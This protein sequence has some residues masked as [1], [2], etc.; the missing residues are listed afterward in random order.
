[1][2]FEVVILET[3]ETILHEVT[4][5]I[6]HLELV[7][8]LEA[9]AIFIHKEGDTYLR[10]DDV[11]QEYGPSLAVLAKHFQ[12]MKSTSTRSYLVCSLNSLF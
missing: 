1:M 5:K 7:E 8:L 3:V 9:L 12:N 6:S 2:L 10:G 11:E 4:K